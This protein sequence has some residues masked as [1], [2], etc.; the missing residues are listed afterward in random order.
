M[1]M[2]NRACGETMNANWL[3]K[4]RITSVSS[5][6]TIRRSAC[7]AR[8][9][10]PR[11]RFQLRNFSSS[12]PSS[13]VSTPPPAF[14]RPISLIANRTGAVKIAL[15]CP[16]ITES[17]TPPAFLCLAPASLSDPSH[18]RHR[19]GQDSAGPAEHGERFDRDA[20]RISSKSTEPRRGRN[21]SE[22][23]HRRLPYDGQERD[24]SVRS[25]P[26]RTQF[27]RVA[28]FSEKKSH[29]VVIGIRDSD[30]LSQ[31]GS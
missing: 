10:P 4:R 30:S 13:P 15:A 29:P 3:A 2:G 16:A 31:H 9:W 6:L 17:S 23:R 28:P 25:P 8:A 5:Q 19:L 22:G 26:A 7:R 24:P 18:G 20:V 12:P 27:R 11:E 1:S 21:G 14:A